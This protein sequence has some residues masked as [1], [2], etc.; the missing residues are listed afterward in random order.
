LLKH[1]SLRSEDDFQLHFAFNGRPGADAS[2]LWTP[3][4]RELDYPDDSSYFTYSHFYATL[5]IANAYRYAIPNPYRSE[6]ILALAESLKILRDLGDP[7]ALSLSNDFPEI[8]GFIENPSPP[9]VLELR[10]ISRDR[11]STAQGELEIQS[12]LE[13]YRTMEE[14]KGVNGLL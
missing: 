10:G 11:L 9:V 1:A 6:F 5:N 7:L 2:A 12:Q 4:L 3:A 8:A 14:F 13:S